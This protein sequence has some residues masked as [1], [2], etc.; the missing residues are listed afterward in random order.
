[1]RVAIVGN[2]SIGLSLGALFSKAG[3]DVIILTRSDVKENIIFAESDIEGLSGRYNALFI[4]R[5]REEGIQKILEK[6]PELVIVTVKAYHLG[7]VVKRL[8]ELKRRGF[9]RPTLF[10]QNGLDI[11]DFVAGSVSNPVRGVT[12]IGAYRKSKNTVFIAG[13]NKTLIGRD[14]GG[15]CEEFKRLRELAGLPVEINETPFIERFKAAINAGINPV[16]AL[17]RIKNGEI[18]EREDAWEVVKRA[19]EETVEVAKAYGVELP[20]DMI[21]IV[22]RGIEL[23]YNNYSSMAMDVLSGRPTEIDRINGKIVEKAEN[24]GLNAPVNRSLRRLIRALSPRCTDIF[25]S[26]PSSS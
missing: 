18:L 16:T 24:K 9:E 13:I 25:P 7:S 10:L 19:T 26:D 14:E 5:E 1:M 21:S 23:T 17:L 8:K 3:V 4:N 6:R 15:K 20:D 11:L 12:G 2:G 22:R